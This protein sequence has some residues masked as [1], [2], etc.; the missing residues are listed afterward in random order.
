MQYWNIAQ[1]MITGSLRSLYLKT[2][3]TNLHDMISETEYFYLQVN[4]VDSSGMP[5]LNIL[6]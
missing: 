1:I 2:G 6:Q 4:E 5:S 3:C